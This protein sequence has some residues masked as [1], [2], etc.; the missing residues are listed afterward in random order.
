MTDSSEKACLI[1]NLEQLAPSCPEHSMLELLAPGTTRIHVEKQPA[2]EQFP[3]IYAEGFNGEKITLH[4]KRDPVGEAERQIEFWMNSEKP[5]SSG[6]VIVTGLGAMHHLK[7]L[8]SRLKPGSGVFAY[9]CDPQGVKL[10]LESMRL[11]EFTAKS[12]S[13]RI[14]FSRDP[15]QIAADFSNFFGRR[16]NLNLS[17]FC[18]PA[19]SGRAYV[20]EYRTIDKELLKTARNIAINRGTLASYLSQW[21]ENAFI[22]MYNYLKSPSVECLRDL[23]KNCTAI[24]CGAGPSLEG[25]L[26]YIKENREKLVIFAAGTALKPLKKAGITADFAVAVDSSPK[27]LPQ[28]SELDVKGSILLAHGQIIPALP[29]IY[30][31]SSIFFS[32]S[33]L[34]GFERWLTSAIPPAPRIRVAGTVLSSVIELAA[35]SGVSKMILCGSDL[36]FKSDGQTHASGSMYDGQ[37]DQGT[38]LLEVEGNWGKKVKTTKQFSL[39]IETVNS[40]LGAA[41]DKGIQIYNATEGGAALRNCTLV[42]PDAIPEIL[43]DSPIPPGLPE[44]RPGVS[45]EAIQAFC[46]LARETETELREVKNIALNC[47]ELSLQMLEHIKAGMNIPEEILNTCSDQE[48]RICSFQLAS[49]LL[50]DSMKS[51]LRQFIPDAGSA[52]PSPA[53][54]A[55]KS[56]MFFERT[57]GS[58]D[59]LISLIA[60]VLPRIQGS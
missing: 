7:S 20:A 17:F 18:H 30:A 44:H 32:A 47:A 16:R 34:P 35:F 31:G 6:T 14:S 8:L 3:L 37:K 26:P 45:E 53:E 15:Q 12:S 58:A 9:D 42:K 22:N 55:E 19:I 60:T 49:Y 59:K 51:F 24:V 50:E 39:Y 21:T 28:F 13:L 48:K 5:D 52:A 56:I 4:S 57:A 1:K 46:K 33:I 25:A 43:Q 11:P 36:A 23:Y 27:T 29:E 10:I 38:N 2:P 41:A 54:S 40:F